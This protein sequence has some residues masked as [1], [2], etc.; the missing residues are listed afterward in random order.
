MATV[1]QIGINLDMKW[2]TIDFKSTLKPLLAQGN[3]H[4]M[5]VFDSVNLGTLVHR[6]QIT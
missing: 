3:L 6:L 4:N 1:K 5:N 2:L